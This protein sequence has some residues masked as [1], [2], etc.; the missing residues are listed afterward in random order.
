MS[1]WADRARIWEQMV[2]RFKWWTSFTPFTPRIDAATSFRS[3]PLGTPSRRMWV[4][5]L[6]PR[7]DP[8]KMTAP[9]ATEMT[10]STTYQL[11]KYITTPPTIT[12][13]EAAA[14]PRTWRKAL[15]TFRSSWEWLWRAPAATR[16]ITRPTAAMMNMGTLF[17]S[18]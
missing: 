1:T 9:I 18:P 11:V 7:H 10:A 15:L 4:D 5:S 2:Q 14:S 3:I 17:T 8:E 13:R 6:S 12:P 16:F